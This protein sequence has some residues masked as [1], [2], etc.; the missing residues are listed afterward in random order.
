M[1]RSQ[2]TPGFI[3]QKPNITLHEILIQLE[4]LMSIESQ[5]RLILS[6]IELIH[7]PISLFNLSSDKNK[8][9]IV[10]ITVY[11]MYTVPQANPQDSK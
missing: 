3:I 9:K 4:I 1:A 6:M 2:P 8:K 7:S 10:N 11:T 5:S